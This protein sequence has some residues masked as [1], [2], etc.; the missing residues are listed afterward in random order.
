[1]RTYSSCAVIVVEPVSH[2]APVLCQALARR[3]LRVVQC[4]TLT[5]CEPYLA[6]FPW[7]VLALYTAPEK[8][9]SVVAFLRALRDRFEHA[10]A[11]AL[12]PVEAV[13]LEPLLREA[14]A[15]DVLYS[16]VQADR[17]ARV[18]L[19]QAA[20]A[21]RQRWA[22]ENWL[23]ARLPWGAESR[24]RVASERPEPR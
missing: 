20:K 22:E 3:R 16:V 8:C 14:G 1:M 21:P 18:V 10:C 17:L 19:R 23:T 5:E 15:I 12:V 2:W 4:R 9:T 11:A 6:A 24:A 13:D 7:S